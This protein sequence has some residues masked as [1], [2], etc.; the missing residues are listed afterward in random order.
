MEHGYR[1]EAGR[2]EVDPWLN[3]ALSALAPAD[4][5]VVLMR[6]F[7][8]L[9]F[10]QIA[11]ETGML[12]NTAVQRAKRAIEK[13]RRFLLKKE[14]T[15]SAAAL[16]ALLADR[17]AD[18]ASDACRA[19][20]LRAVHQLAV[21]HAA[22]V[23]ASPHL[24]LLQKGVTLTMLATKYKVTAGVS[25]AV[26]AA[27]LI[28]GAA[29]QHARAAQAAARPVQ[30]TAPQPVDS[31]ARTAEQQIQKQ[32]GHFVHGYNARNAAEIMTAMSQD[33]VFTS[34]EYGKPVY[35]YRD[36]AANGQAMFSHNAPDAHM[37]MTV[38]SF[39]VTG[40]TAVLGTTVFGHG[41]DVRQLPNGTPEYFDSASTITVTFTN[42]G[43]QWLITRGEKLASTSSPYH[44]GG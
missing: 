17:G 26:L 42:T 28:T 7:D 39:T 3:D 27:L 15:I 38:S 41:T 10:Q 30:W 16:A 14:V 19:A 21:G 36:M 20:T 44:P 5:E 2:Q 13:M 35:P 11:A 18:A 6:Y 9:T 25:A 12:E 33:C 43:G 32:L 34:R 31:A 1:P 22:T 8:D 4:R 23:A 40:N 37:R 29:Y 24:A